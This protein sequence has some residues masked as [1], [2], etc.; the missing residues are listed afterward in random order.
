MG[1]RSSVMSY[2]KSAEVGRIAL[3]VQSLRNISFH[4]ETSMVSMEPNELRELM[5]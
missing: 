2:Q 1:V 5:Q 4:L 3:I